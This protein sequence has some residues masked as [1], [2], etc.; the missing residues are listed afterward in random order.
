MID[1]FLAFGYSSEFFPENGF[2]NFWNFDEGKD[3]Y[4]VQDI[5]DEEDK[6][7]AV[8]QGQWERVF[9][10]EDKLKKDFPSDE[11]IPF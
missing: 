4:I 10:K 5:F 1:L 6:L 7:K 9:V 8:D 11:D 2:Y 3:I